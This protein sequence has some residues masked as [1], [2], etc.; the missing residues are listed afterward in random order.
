MIE[1][2]QETIKA[3]SHT[4]QYKMH[5][6][7]AR[8]PYN[9]FSNLIKYYTKENDIV[10]DVF[11]GGGVTVFESL[12]LKRNVI[13]NDLNPLA[14]FITEMQIFNGDLDK[15][16][17]EIESFVK[18]IKSKFSKYYYI[19][20]DDD[21]GII[22]WVEWAYIVKCPHC[23][24]DII[25]SDENKIKNGVYKCDNDSCEGFNGI[26]RTGC[27]SNGSIPIRI[28]YQSSITK[29]TKVCKFDN[30]KML[31]TNTYN[32][33]NLE[34]YYP[35]FKFPMDW[36]RQKE[37]K[38]LEKGIVQYKD[39]FTKR[40]FYINTLIFKE[41]QESKSEYKDYLYFIFSSSLRYTNNM[42][43][44]TE[45]WEN[46]NPTSMD[47]HAYWFPNLY[48]ENNVLKIFEKR[49]E[50]IYKGCEFSKNKLHKDTNK[51]SRFSDIKINSS[52]ILNT[53]SS[54][55]PLPDESVD[56][57]ITDP[58]YGSNVQYAELSVVWN[59]WF[60]LYKNKDS[61]IYRTR[62][63]VSNRKT[64]YKNSKSDKDYSNLLF[65]VFSES[66]RV[67]KDKSY[68][69][70]TFNNKNIKT[71]IAM[72]SAVSK[73]GFYLPTNGII[74]QDYIDSY[75]NTAH[76]KYDGNISGDFIYSFVKD[77]SRNSENCSPN[78]K[79]IDEFLEN[80]VV[81]AIEEIFYKSK[82]LTTYELYKQLFSKIVNSLMSVLKSCSDEE[83]NQLYSLKD[84]YLE[85]LLKKHLNY[86]NGEWSIKC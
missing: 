21:K 15:L 55:L 80:T 39:I 45:N 58:P 77:K 68:L 62:E 38:L 71:W 2:I 49:A 42:T 5:K 64:N 30:E 41:I 63:A 66:Y 19:D 28:K 43:R 70:F 31:D 73:S 44:V 74:F 22:E 47:K 8:R 54:H 72:L 40:N 25:L 32:L 57:I 65:D 34:G 48:I 27:T 1:P 85:N 13:G 17:F 51:V 12:A 81:S 37:D 83:L 67:L 7:F 24:K 9:V 59:A 6:Y 23:G 3:E 10:L 26:K 46:G 35:N 14:S 4:P 53:D 50:A 52:L 82:D 69:V 76:L 11:C 18:H 78:F 86:D 56:I 84:N 16:K 29:K 60:Q 79:T 75:K 36:D 61:Y 33:S 20:L